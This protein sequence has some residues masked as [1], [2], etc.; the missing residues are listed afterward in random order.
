MPVVGTPQIFSFECLYQML[1]IVAR[2]HVTLSTPRIGQSYALVHLNSRHFLGGSRWEIHEPQTDNVGIVYL[3]LKAGHNLFEVLAKPNVVFD[4]D[5]PRFLGIHQ[6]LHRSQVSQSGCDSG[7]IGHLAFKT[8]LSAEEDFGIVGQ[9][10]RDENNVKVKGL[11]CGKETRRA[12]RI[13]VHGVDAH[14]YVD[15]AA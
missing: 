5:T 11:R 3:G 1:R 14:V 4:N 8:L 13:A 12:T 2:N 6:E 15:N 9:R 10:R 7:G